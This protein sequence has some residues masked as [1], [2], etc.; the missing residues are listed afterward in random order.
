MDLKHTS[1]CR[2]MTSAGRLSSNQV[3]ELLTIQWEMQN[4]RPKSQGTKS[5]S[6]SK[7]FINPHYHQ[8]LLLVNQKLLLVNLK[9][10]WTAF[11]SGYPTRNV[12][13]KGTESATTLLY[14]D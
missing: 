2:L 9:R 7:P 3:T 11:V 14:L 12:D 1:L 4:W 13:N 5:L 10:F 6:D 8:K